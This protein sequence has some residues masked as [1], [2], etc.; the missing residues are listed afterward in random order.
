MLHFAY[1]SNMSRVLMRKNAPDAEPAG[2]AALPDYRFV[3]TVDGYASVEPM[4]GQRVHGVLW[5]LTPGDRATLDAWESVASGLYRV[6][7]LPVHHADRDVAA[8]VYIAE[9]G[10]VGQPKAGYMQTVL[11]AASAWNLPSAYIAGLRQ[12]LPAHSPRIGTAEPGDVEWT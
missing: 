5:R 3:I 9:R 11:A 10:A 8:L 2:V 1:G 7:T 4:R 12:W 6:E